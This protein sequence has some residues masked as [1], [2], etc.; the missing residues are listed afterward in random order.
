MGVRANMKN[1]R[2]R[3]MTISVT[4]EVYEILKNSSNNMSL[5]ICDLVKEYAYQ[6]ENLGK[7]DE[8]S[9]QTEA[10]NTLNSINQ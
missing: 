9:R 8:I 10:I 3:P 5:F 1:Y 6:G 2:K 4:D 7:Y